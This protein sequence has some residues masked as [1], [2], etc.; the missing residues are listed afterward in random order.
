[1]TVRAALSACAFPTCGINAARTGCT[2][3]CRQRSDS[4]VY[5]WDDHKLNT[6][7]DADD[8]V[9]VTRKINGGENGLAHRKELL[10]KANGLLGMLELA[11]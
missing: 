9:G 7:A 4:A 11:G 3:S 1:V 8:V 2:A 6:L 5:F 10:N